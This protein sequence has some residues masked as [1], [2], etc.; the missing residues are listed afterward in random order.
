MPKQGGTDKTAIRQFERELLQTELK[1]MNILGITAVIIS[2]LFIVMSFIPQWGYAAQPGPLRLLIA[3]GLV[4]AVIYPFLVRRFILKLLAANRTY[5]IREKYLGAF[6]EASLPTILILVGSVAIED[7][8]AA[9]NS[10]AYSLYFLTIAVSILRLDG[11]ICLFIGSMVTL[12]YACLAIYAVQNFSSTQESQLVFEPF[13]HSGKAL[14]LFAT[15]AIA[16]WLSN[17][18]KIKAHQSIESLEGH[19]AQLV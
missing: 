4:V 1:R 9:L 19:G 8:P 15:G 3:G 5:P 18:I 12:Q 16:A 14:I 7:L 2:T 17:S 13:Y 6:F 10:P 11:K